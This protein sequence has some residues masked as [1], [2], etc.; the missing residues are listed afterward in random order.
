MPRLNIALYEEAKIYKGKRY[1]PNYLDRMFSIVKEGVVAAGGTSTSAETTF[2]S[3]PPGK[4][5]LLLLYT[6]P[7]ITIIYTRHITLKKR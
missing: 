4:Y 3:T 2:M 1:L 7:V 6:S 5:T